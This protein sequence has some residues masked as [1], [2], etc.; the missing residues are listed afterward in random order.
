M[1]SALPGSMRFQ[2]NTPGCVHRPSRGIETR[3]AVRDGGRDCGRVARPLRHAN[4]VMAARAFLER[5]AEAL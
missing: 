1:S 3:R 5:A 4:A 2:L